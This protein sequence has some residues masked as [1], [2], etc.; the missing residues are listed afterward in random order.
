LKAPSLATHKSLVRDQV[1][2]NQRDVYATDPVGD[3]ND[4]TGASIVDMMNPANNDAV[5][6]QDLGVFEI[7]PQHITAAVS[8]D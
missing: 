7:T 4:V 6:V 2:S 1:I 5:R 3:L 8:L